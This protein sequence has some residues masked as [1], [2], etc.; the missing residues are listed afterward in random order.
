MNRPFENLATLPPPSCYVHPLSLEKTL[1][2]SF[3]RS[4]I[5][6]VFSYI[7]EVPQTA[8]R[9]ALPEKFNCPIHPLNIL[10]QPNQPCSRRF[11]D[12]MLSFFLEVNQ[13]IAYHFLDFPLT[14]NM[15]LMIYSSTLGCTTAVVQCA[16]YL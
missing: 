12:I 4:R 9:I 10:F 5:R 15:Q 1:N 11:V 16:V 7:F 14:G 3:L 2:S 6:N 8:K 13:L